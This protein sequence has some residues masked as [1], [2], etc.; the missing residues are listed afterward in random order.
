MTRKKKKIRKKKKGRQ[1]GRAK[2]KSAKIKRLNVSVIQNRCLSM[3]V[4]VRK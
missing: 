4:Q 3:G 1:M 2:E